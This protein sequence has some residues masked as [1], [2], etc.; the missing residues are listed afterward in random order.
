VVS[1]GEEAD[2]RGQDPDSAPPADLHDEITRL[3]AKRDRLSELLDPLYPTVLDTC[4]ELGLAYLDAGR[5]DLAIPLLTTNLEHRRRIMG[6]DYVDTLD[7]A[8]ALAAAHLNAGHTIQALAR[9]HIN[10]HSCRRR[11]LREDHPTTLAARNLQ[12]LAYLSVGRGRKARAVLRRTL[13]A[14]RRVLGDE[15]PDTMATVDNLALALGPKRER[16][17]AIYLLQHNVDRE[18]RILG[19]THPRTL[20]STASLGLMR[21]EAGF[22]GGVE[23]VEDALR[24]QRAS[25][26]ADN[27]GSLATAGKLALAQLA[28]ARYEKGIALLRET[29]ARCRSNLGR[30]DK[31]TRRLSRTLMLERGPRRPVRWISRTIRRR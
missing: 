1:A 12:G 4:H 13:Q 27:R 9:V 29:V 14:R 18:H 8:T 17:E 7:S 5:L 21:A 23:T 31:L 6:K 28:E 10:L 2:A 22:F 26:G 3:E 25:W 20:S 24:K 16:R 30:R 11:F 15:H 19:A